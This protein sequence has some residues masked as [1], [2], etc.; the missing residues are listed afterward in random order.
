M[1]NII[2]KYFSVTK[3]INCLGAPIFALALRGLLFHD[4]FISGWLKFNYIWNDQ[5]STV[6]YLF[7]NEYKVPLLSPEV[8][9]ALSVFNELTFSTLILIGLATRFSA[10][11]LLLM[12]IV[13]ELSYGYALTHYIWFIC[14]TYLVIY[15]GGALSLDFLLEKKMRSRG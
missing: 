8:A 11:I 3:W 13:I 2:N 7:T 9:G 10:L 12:S 6:V 15:G 4:F 1:C 5:W 14:A